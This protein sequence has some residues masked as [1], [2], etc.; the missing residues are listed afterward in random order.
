MTHTVKSIVGMKGKLVFAVSHS[1][2]S[3]A[4]EVFTPTTTRRE[5]EIDPGRASMKGEAMM[6]NNHF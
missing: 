1:R 2:F 6:G 4:T 5:A 3:S